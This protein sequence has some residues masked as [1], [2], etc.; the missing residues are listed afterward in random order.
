MVELSEAK[1]HFF[2]VEEVPEDVD[3]V[4][5][6]VVAALNAAVF[7][8]EEQFRKVTSVALNHSFDGFEVA[9][10]EMKLKEES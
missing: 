1:S 6:E 7:A 8:R 4:A 9:A 5:D 10:R 3:G 2:V